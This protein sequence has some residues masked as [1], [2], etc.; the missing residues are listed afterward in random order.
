MQRVVRWPARLSALSLIISGCTTK[1]DR[2]ARVAG[3]QTRASLV[4]GPASA[5][6]ELGPLLPFHKD[7]I[8]AGLTIDTFGSPKICFWMRPS[9][10]K[11]TDLVDP[12]NGPIGTFKPEFNELVYGGFGFSSTLDESVKSRIKADIPLDNTLCFDMD[13]PD[14]FKNT[15]KFRVEDLT[16]QD[17]ALNAAAFTNAGG[18]GGGLNYNVFCSGNVA[19]ADGRWAM[20]GGHDKTG[21]AGIRKIL[22]FDPNDESWKSRP[23]PRVKS[24]FE[25]DPSGTEFEHGS[26]RDE[27]NTD[28]R[29]PSDMK[30]QRWYPTAVTL[31][32]RK[33]LVLSGSDLDTSLG[34]EN[35]NAS[36]VRQPAPEIY[37]PAADRTFALENARKLLAM[38]PRSYP[39]QTGRGWQ[40]WEVAVIG[41][42]APP[43]PTAEE[44]RNNY[45]PYRYDGRTYLLDVLGASADP[46]R[47][48]PAED[49]WTLVANAASAHESGAGAALWTLDEMGMPSSQRIALFGGTNGS[50]S[51]ASAIVEMID[52]EE[53]VPAWRQQQPLERPASQNNAVALPDG[54]VVIVGGRAGRGSTAVNT[55]A[56]Q[57][58]DPATGTM[59]SVAE[60]TVPRHDHSTAVLLHDGSVMVMGGNRTELVPGNSSAGVPVAQIYKP[61]YLF[62]GS[63]PVIDDWPG[64][65]SYGSRFGID[66]SGHCQ[67]ITSVVLSRLG[68]ITHNWDWGNRHVRLSFE[69]DGPGHLTVAAPRVPAAAVPGKYLLFVVGADGVPS[70][71]QLIRLGN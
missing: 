55:Y 70:V 37:D 46:S 48:D 17:F 45:D 32:D 36:K 34:P 2:D 3:S 24:E 61:P 63:R 65:I 20:V 23:E 41:A 43:L 33:V 40:D 56:V 54:K 4:S 1:D 12:D 14:A 11:G 52:F 10:Y 47:D 44:I 31:P 68:P 53:A 13:H 6:G 21:N 58:F 5:V 28:P 57:L 59:Q 15:G 16:E 30:Y 64:T 38:Y 69:Q 18:R 7:A 25:E 71:G 42:V 60:T 26:A 8:A 39:V 67:G 51:E 62:R 27:A 35:A 49:H 9:E 22:I 29:I 50:G 19:L 66:V